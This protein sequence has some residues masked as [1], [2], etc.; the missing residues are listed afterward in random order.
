MKR[1]TIPVYCIV[2]KLVMGVTG[3]VS[4]ETYQV[5]NVTNGGSIKGIVS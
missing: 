4:G 5:I 3:A 1:A 2:P